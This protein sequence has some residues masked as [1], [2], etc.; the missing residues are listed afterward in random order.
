MLIEVEFGAKIIWLA[1]VPFFHDVAGGIVDGIFCY[2][3]IGILQAFCFG[4]GRYTT[5]N[6][7]PRRFIS[8]TTA[9]R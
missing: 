3:R 5:G 8:V 9:L 1:V 7:L 4:V 2:P 6:A